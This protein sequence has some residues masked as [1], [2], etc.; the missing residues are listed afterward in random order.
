M[1]RTE[2]TFTEFCFSDL[3]TLAKIHVQAILYLYSNCSV[4]SQLIKTMFHEQ[5]NQLNILGISYMSLLK[6]CDWTITPEPYG[7]MPLNFVGGVCLIQRTLVI[8]TVFVTKDFAVKSN[9][10]L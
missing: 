9:L 4:T 6:T 5:G 1:F 2:K 3:S 7:I 10:L 8:T